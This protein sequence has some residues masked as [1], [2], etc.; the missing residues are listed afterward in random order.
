MTRIRYDTHMDKGQGYQRAFLELAIRL[1]AL[2]FG[3]FTLKSGRQSPYFF[4]AGVFSTG[5][6]IAA[7]GRFYAETIVATGFKF[8]M[9]FGPAYKGIPLAAVSAAA[10]AD[11]H[12][13]D[14]GFAYNRK[15]AK[16]HGEGGSI[17]G[18]KVAGR[19]LIV[20]DV[21]TA[22]TAIRQAVEL[23][24]DAGAEVAGVVLALDRQE[25]GQGSRSAVQELSREL[26]A[27]VASIASLGD[28]M[29][30]VAS[31]E[32]LSRYLPAMEDYRRHYGV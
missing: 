21:I 12:C 6:A 29:A 20:D 8:D 13:I 23:I 31:D 22:G 4:N 5:S 26:A 27:P 16:Q 18:A 32:G 28:L 25:R 3:R 24:R 10:L 1:G 2:G 19:V 17:V 7:L 11:H 14:S 30:L 15:E 9:L